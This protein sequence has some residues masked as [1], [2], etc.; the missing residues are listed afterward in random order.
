VRKIIAFENQA[1]TAADLQLPVWLGSPEYT[2]T[3]NAMA[4]G[5]GVSL[6]RSKGPTWL[7]PWF[8][9]GNPNDPF[10][11]VPSEQPKKFTEQMKQGGILGVLMGHAN[12]DS[13]YSMRFEG[14]PV[15]YT[16]ADAAGVFAKGPPVPPM[17]FF[18]CETGK[19]AEPTPCQAKALLMMPG[20]PVATIGATTESHPLP[21][22]LSS[23][24]LLTELGGNGNRLG[25]IWFHAQRA[26]LHNHDAIMEMMLADAEGSLEKQINVEK[27]R[28]DQFLMYELLGDPAT[29]LRLPERLQVK[30]E[31]RGQSWQWQAVKPAGA[32]HLEIGYR[33]A[34]PPFVA[35]NTKGDDGQ[36]RKAFAAANAGFEF[37][38]LP[39][40]KANETWQGTYEKPGL[41]RLIAIGPGTFSAAVVKLQ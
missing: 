7:R 36:K 38:A 13:F 10:C 15:F 20:G 26:A 31:H 14:R 4:S 40:L 21:N 9:S 35:K 25:Q 17:V 5:L 19:F 27:L 23:E 34:S 33:S 3:I 29:K 22:Y 18:S 6:I 39:P 41:I 24:C 8:I 28:R 37:A 2:P 32:T 11:G 30:L 12:A 1:P 16:A